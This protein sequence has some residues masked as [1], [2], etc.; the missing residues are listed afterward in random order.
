[1]K[2]KTLVP[3]IVFLLGIMCL[4]DD[5]CI[6]NGSPTKK[7]QTHVTAQLNAATYGEDIKNKITNGIEITDALK[8]VLIS[9]D[10]A[11]HQFDTIAKNLISDSIES[12]QLAPDGVVTDIYPAEGNEAGKIDLLP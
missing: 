6:Q 5:N 7:A 3:L 10:G 11:I 9:E 8:Q 12:V 2:K 1:M 4:P